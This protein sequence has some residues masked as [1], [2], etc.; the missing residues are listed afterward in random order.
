[1][2]FFVKDTGRVIVRESIPSGA[3]HPA[4]KNCIQSMPIYKT[5]CSRATLT[6]DISNEIFAIFP[7]TFLVFNDTAFTTPFTLD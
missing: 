1:L 3:K 2:S 7:F 5:G 6:G 4:G